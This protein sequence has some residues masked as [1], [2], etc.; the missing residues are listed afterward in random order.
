M[1]ARESKRANK[2]FRKESDGRALLREIYRAQ[3]GKNYHVDKT[4]KVSG[5][6]IHLKEL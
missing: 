5:R 6:T 2:I 1:K 4:V 3:S